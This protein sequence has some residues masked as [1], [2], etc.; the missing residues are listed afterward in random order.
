VSPWALVAILIRQL[1]EYITTAPTGEEALARAERAFK[2][3]ASEQLSEAAIERALRKSA[4][5]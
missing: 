5:R 3:A 2:A 1:V 4:L